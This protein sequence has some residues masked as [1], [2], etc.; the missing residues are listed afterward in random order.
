MKIPIKEQRATFRFME[1]ENLDNVEK[2]GDFLVDVC[3]IMDVN[4][5]MRPVVVSYTDK[6]DETKS[7]VSAVV[8]F[9]E[10]S[11]VVHTWSKLNYAA[12]DIYSCKEFDTKYIQ[13]A[14]M[15]YFMPISL[16]V[17]NEVI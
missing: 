1:A 13:D 15:Q 5:I 14:I 8:I 3:A 12:V 10:S 17:L 2:I 11:I 9:A 7:G 4:M 16:S 6:N